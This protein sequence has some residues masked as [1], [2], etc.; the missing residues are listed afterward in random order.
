MTNVAIQKTASNY[1]RNVDLK[2][3]IRSLKLYL[4]SKYGDERVNQLFSD[5]QNTIIKSLLSVQKVMINDKHCFEMY[6]YDIMIDDNLK[7]WLVEVNSSPSLSYTTDE[8]YLLKFALLND[9]LDIVNVENKS[10]DPNLLQ[11]G[12]LDLI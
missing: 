9:V 8:D 7:V 3:N 1:D 10:R 5:I 12:G 2:W 4:I 6:G 11:L